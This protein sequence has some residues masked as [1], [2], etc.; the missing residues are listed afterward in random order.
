MHTIGKTLVKPAA[1]QMANIM[2]GKAAKDKLA[3][4]PFSNDFVKSPINDISEDIFNQVVADVK[5]SPT[6]FSLQLDKTT[7]VVN[8]KQLIALVRYVKEHEIKKEFLFCKHLTT[9][10]AI[11]MKKILDDFFT[12][13]VFHGTWF[14]QCA[15]MGLLPR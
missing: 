13:T 3:L 2:L 9:A 15:P 7:D 5:A 8:L 10:K 6:K 1:L 11:D 4:V 14:P 12:I